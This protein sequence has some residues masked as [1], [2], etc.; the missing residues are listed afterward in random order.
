MDKPLRL[1]L[2]AT[3]LFTAPSSLPAQ[4]KRP[5][6]C[7]ADLEGGVPYL[8]G[9]KDDPESQI[10][11]EV[12]LMNALARQL[13]RPITRRHTEFDTLIPALDRGDFDF[14]LNGLEISPMNLRQATFTRPYYIYQLQLI[15]RADD[16]RFTSLDD[17]KSMDLTVSTLGGSS[18]WRLLQEKG[19]KTASYTDQEGPFKVLIEKRVDAV[20]FD[21]PI[22]LYYVAPDD[23]IAHRKKDY[24]GLKFVGTP[25]A[26]GYYGI[27]VKKDNHALAKELDDALGRII[28]SGELKQI[29]TD[30]H[31]WSPDQYGLYTTLDTGI[32]PE[33]G[34]PWWQALVLLLLASVETIRI[35]LGGMAMAV[36]LGLVIAT[37]RLYAPLPFRWLAIAYVEFFRGIPVLLL[38]YFLF[39]GLPAMGIKLDP[40]HAAILGFGLN[41]AAYEAEIYRNGI[42]SIPIGQWEA[43]AS[44]GMSPFLTF[45][46]II[47]PQ[48]IRTILPPMTNDFIALFKDTS[49]VSVVSVIELSKEYQILT[50]TYGGFLQIGL[51]TAGLYLVMSVPLGY[52]SRYLEKRWGV[53]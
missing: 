39:F 21:S 44:L 16:N 41:Y 7:G 1:F 32:Q 23:R 31:L 35:S 20:L 33:G 15:G 30:W 37:T 49:V 22:A 52:L 24:P 50:K 13:G 34:M 19:I 25:M 48:S 5:L 4:E 45:R 27:A 17:C 38:I 40:L 8:F 3:L 10:G 53:K 18:A 6:V 28:E 43:A 9:S 46:R 47:F 29:L 11:F 51:M 26:A 12:D 2:L 36:A 42:Q 14:A